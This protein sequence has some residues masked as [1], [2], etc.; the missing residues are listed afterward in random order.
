MTDEQPEFRV[1]PAALEYIGNL[2]E[3]AHIHSIGVTFEP[4]ETG[5]TVGYMRGIGDCGGCG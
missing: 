4:D 3:A 2:L 5:W 1:T